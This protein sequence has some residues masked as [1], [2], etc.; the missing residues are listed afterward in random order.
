MR[1]LAYVLAIICLIAAVVYFAMPAG[2]LPTFMPGSQHIHTTHA[3]AA[4]IGAVILFVLGLFASRAR[5]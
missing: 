1:M 2:S 4:V 5:A 3:I